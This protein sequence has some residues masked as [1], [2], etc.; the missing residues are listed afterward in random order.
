MEVIMSSLKKIF[1]NFS[2]LFVLSGQTFAWAGSINLPITSFSQADGQAKF[3]DLTQELGL[4]I[5]SVQASP[6][7]PLGIIGFDV[8]VEVT[9]A[10]ISSKEGFWKDATSSKA[11]GYLPIPKLHVQKGLPFGIDVGATYSSAPGLD[12]SIVGAEVKYAILSG[13]IA[14]PAVAVRA[15]Y[16]KLMDVDALDLSTISADLSVSKGVTFVTPFVGVGMVKT[17][18]KENVQGLDLKEEEQDIQRSFAGVKIS[19]AVINFVF[20]ADFSEIPLYTLRINVG[21]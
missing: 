14:L 21:L 20:Q 4:A 19:L 3:K 6:A 18:A 17:S 2:L 8:G 16:T 15:G 12:F 1:F 11:P 13:N 7:E 10:K 5:S 9:A